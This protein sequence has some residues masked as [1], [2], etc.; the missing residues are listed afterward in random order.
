MTEPGPPRRTNVLALT[1]L[2]AGLCGLSLVPLVGSVV[3][4][5]T[6]HLALNQV[7][8]TG[9]DGEVLAK[10]GL[11]LGYLAIALVVLAV[12]FLLLV[13]LFRTTS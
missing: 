6:G 3:A 12:A 4:V 1:S 2:I 9:E 7:R 11:W 5:V 10:A 13:V 8:E